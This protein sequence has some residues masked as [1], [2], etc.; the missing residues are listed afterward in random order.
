MDYE[1][2]DVWMVL[3]CFPLLQKIKNSH[4][5]CF[6][7]RKSL[8]WQKQYFCNWYS[9]KDETKAC[10]QLC[11]VG[12]KITEEKNISNKKSNKEFFFMNLTKNQIIVILVVQ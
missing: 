2:S 5:L 10:G 8:F 7:G 12:L 6:P 11:R 1:I 9:V 3:F 4:I